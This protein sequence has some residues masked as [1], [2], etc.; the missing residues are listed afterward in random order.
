VCYFSCSLYIWGYFHILTFP[1][2]VDGV[3][4]SEDLKL[5]STGL[6]PHPCQHVDHWHWWPQS[7]RSWSQTQCLRSR[8]QS[9]SLRSRPQSH[10]G[11][12]AEWVDSGSSRLNCLTG[13]HPVSWLVCWCL[14]CGWQYHNLYN[15]NSLL[16][17]QQYDD[18]FLKSNNCV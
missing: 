13:L 15:T 18:Y 16:N 11:A 3:L 1:A 9:Q 5:R 10:P 4:Y 17:V 2:C 14:P 12:G 8:S 7:L 6:V